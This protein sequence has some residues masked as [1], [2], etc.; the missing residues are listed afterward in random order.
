M[1]NR[2]AKLPL[3]KTA[4]A[5][6]NKSVGGRKLSMSESDYP[7]RV[8]WM[9]AY[10][11]AGG[12]VEA[13]DSKKGIKEVKKDCPEV[14]CN[15]TS[16]TFATSPSDRS[17][18]RI[19]VGEE[20]NLNYSPGNAKWKIS[21]KGKISSKNGSSI[22]FTAGNKSGSTTI[23]ATGSGGSCSLT[24]TVISP[25]SMTMN[26]CP[27]KNLKHT[28]NR[29]DCGWMGKVFVH[30]DD[31]NF[32]RVEIRELDSAAVTT[33]SYTVFKG[34]KHG[35]YPAPDH[36]SSWFALIDHS[37]AAGS[38][39]GNAIQDNIY[40]G[41]PG[42]AKTGNAPP[43]SIGTMYFPMTWQWRVIGF[44]SKKKFPAFRQ[45]HELKAVGICSTSKASHSEQCLYT[46]PTSTP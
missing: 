6:A 16:Q 25:T 30:P 29:P 44:A 10:I 8:K 35:N 38:S 3:N 22:T 23:K 21:G 45:E 34:V 12:E 43:F 39:W 42:P 5:A 4:V 40:S 11:A 37:D 28:I 31:V 17:R 15:I 9:D 24:F 19:G 32:Y 46:D 13:N 14:K 26:K 7:D 2:R 18:T 27:G 20:V 1:S 41:D 36:A 33:G